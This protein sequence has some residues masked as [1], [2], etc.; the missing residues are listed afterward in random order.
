MIR[1]KVLFSGRQ[2]AFQ[3]LFIGT[4]IYVTVLGFFND[5]TSIV[6]AKSF[7]TIFYASIVL[8]V[9]SYLTFR[10]KGR[11]VR[12]LKS[13]N[14][15]Q[16]FILSSLSTWLVM[17]IAKFVYVWV[18]D[19]I[20]NEYIDIRGFFGILLVVLAASTIHRA[21]YMIF[22]RLGGSDSGLNR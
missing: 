5:C 8:E 4:L 2:L 3:E 15:K 6:V 10:L 1:G 14:G 21:T 12:W 7:S 16:Y 17:F 18:L 19:V 20:F 13:R 11:I 9:L 22:W